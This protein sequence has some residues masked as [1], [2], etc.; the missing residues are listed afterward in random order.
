MPFF[1]N[2]D[3]QYYSNLSYFINY[4]GQENEFHILNTLD[5]SYHGAKPYHYFELWLNSG[6]SKLANANNILT[7]HIVSH[8]VL[9]FI[10]LLGFY[11][12]L[13]LRVERNFSSKYKL[14]LLCFIIFLT[15]LYSTK[16]IPIIGKSL[17][18]YL[19]FFTISFTSYHRFK[20]IY[21]YIF[22]QAFALCILTENDKLGKLLILGL[23]IAAF[24]SAP[25][26]VGGLLL[27][28]LIQYL[29]KK[30]LPRKSLYDAITILGIA[31][32]ILIFFYA[33][34]NDAV[35]RQGTSTSNLLEW[36]TFDTSFFYNI[37]KVLFGSIVLLSLL[38]GLI[39]FL[40]FKAKNNLSYKF[41]SI[42][43]NLIW[44]F[45]SFL[46][47]GLG[48]WVLLLPISSSVQLFHNVGIAAINLLLVIFLLKFITFKNLKKWIK[49]S[50]IC[51]L[52][53]SCLMVV[54]RSLYERRKQIQ[55]FKNYS[56]EYIHNIQEFLKHQKDIVYGASFRKPSSYRESQPTSYYTTI[57]VTGHYLPFLK[58]GVVP[59]SLSDFDAKVESDNAKEKNRM[60]AGLELGIFYRYVNNSKA[61]G[62]FQSIEKSQLE[63]IKKYNLKYAIADHKANI[64]S[65]L[66]SIVD[67]KL[68]DP[69]S[70]QTFLIFK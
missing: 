56:S 55:Y 8:S 30:E 52:V 57:Y 48:A 14:P 17:S 69:I 65:E 21:Y 7:L 4:T 64:S 3:Y 63:F 35:S 70:K 42:E 36:Y 47:A 45:A 40:L 11:S 6:I 32:M 29:R 1:A 62:D 15:G 68:V 26:I 13:D 61:R 2:V 18:E 38:Y 39:G 67:K 9:Y 5:S 51:Y 23:P 19:D 12:L 53:L 33:T 41:N 10:G 59:I 43:I 31:A 22:L 44:G 16:M 34:S 24:T 58:N 66:D 37:I 60:L 49:L 50:L 27:F 54:D 46:I 25:S 20:Y 28:T